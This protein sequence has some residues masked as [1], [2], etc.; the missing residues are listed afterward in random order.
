MSRGIVSRKG[1]DINKTTLSSIEY[2]IDGGIY[3]GCPGKEIYYSLPFFNLEE[4]DQLIVL[5]LN[6]FPMGTGRSVHLSLFWRY[7][8]GMF[9]K[10][11]CLNDREDV[12]GKFKNSPVDWSLYF[13]FV[14]RFLSAAEGKNPYAYIIASEMYAHRLGDQYLI[15]QKKVYFKQMIEMY[16][17]TISLSTQLSVAKNSFSAPYWCCIYLFKMKKF[18]QSYY[19]GNLF[20]DNCNKYCHSKGAYNK[21]RSAVGVLYQISTPEQWGEILEKCNNFD[22]RLVYKMWKRAFECKSQWHL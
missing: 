10:W 5:I 11:G 22:N 12:L 19:Y 4:K 18:D 21:M 15:N 6:A 7:L 13:D 8:Y 16:D 3:M 17:K 14:E 20:L 2:A 9:D 1:G